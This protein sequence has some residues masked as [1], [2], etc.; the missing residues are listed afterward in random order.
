MIS[1][2]VPSRKELLKFSLVTTATW[3]SSPINALISTAAITLSNVDKKHCSFQLASLNPATILYD[4]SIYMFAF[5]SISATNLIATAV[6]QERF[7][8]TYTI[9]N[10]A[11]AASVV[12]G[13]LLTIAATF[14]F[15]RILEFSGTSS[16]SDIFPSAS[17][18]SIIR[19]YGSIF[20]L[21]YMTLQ[22]IFLG[23]RIIITPLKS[24]LLSCM[25]SIIGNTYM[26]FAAKDDMLK[27]SAF[28]S[29]VSEL[30][31][32]CY[33]LCCLYSLR[34]ERSLQHSRVILNN[35]S[36][37][38]DT[39][40]IQHSSCVMS[41]NMTAFPPCHPHNDD[42][43]KKQELVEI[44]TY[45]FNIFIQFFSENISYS[46]I[47]YAVQGCT[48][49]T[50]ATHLVFLRILYFYCTVGEGKPSRGCI[51]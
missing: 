38:S 6:A 21:L 42:S 8:D 46:A 30:V 45:C 47:T 33:M 26:P 19:S 25:C 20:S 24:A 39:C 27:L 2:R 22:G 29:I 41:H 14:L 5:I 13:S 17:S 10:Y 36:T 1:R 48:Q 32:S 35:K 11:I 16:K 3:F 4:S 28:I 40:D 18:F 43:Q 50:L 15:P 44:L 23:H 12:F 37:S 31:P 7:L 51:P 9:E 34:Q 49:E